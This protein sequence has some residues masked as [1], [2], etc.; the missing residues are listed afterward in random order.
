MI[1][2][3]R[4]QTLFMHKLVV[5]LDALCFICAILLEVGIQ[6]LRVYRTIF[7]HKSTYTCTNMNLV[8]FQLCTATLSL[9]KGGEGDLGY[10]GTSLK[11][12]S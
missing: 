10:S 6:L 7:V 2:Y 9:G 1:L 8:I 5:K 4:K 11:G 3:K 12:H